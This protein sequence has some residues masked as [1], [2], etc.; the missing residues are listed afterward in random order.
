MPGKAQHPL[1]GEPRHW[2]TMEVT[3]YAMPQKQITSETLRKMEGFQGMI[4][5]G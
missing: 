3:S 4:G 5:V 1:E 2:L